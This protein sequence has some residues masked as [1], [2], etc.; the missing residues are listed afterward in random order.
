MPECYITLNPLAIQVSHDED[1]SH[2]EVAVEDIPDS[3]LENPYYI[4]WRN[5][6]EKYCER[7]KI[8]FNPA[9]R[10]CFNTY[11]NSG[12]M[13]MEDVDELHRLEQMN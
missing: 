8:S 5:F 1:D 13:T 7:R 12:E 10:F 3:V 4:N 11:L 6:A 2:E 9:V